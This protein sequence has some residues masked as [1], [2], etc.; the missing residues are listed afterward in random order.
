M[1]R[2]K[3]FQLCGAAISTYCDGA[4]STV[5]Q[6]R[7]Q[8]LGVGITHGLLGAFGGRHREVGDV[9]YVDE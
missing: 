9:E 6:T 1:E 4:T 2:D 7:N 5:G 8:E 3:N